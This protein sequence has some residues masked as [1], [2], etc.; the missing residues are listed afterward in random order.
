[1]SVKT[2][3]ILGSTGSI[4]TQ[5]VSLAERLGIKITSL[6]AHSNIGLL[7]VQARE[8]KVN[9]VCC[10]D[11]KAAEKLK[12]NLSDTS[13]RVYAG[14]GGLAQ[15]AA[16]DNAD[17]LLNAVVGI[18][19]LVPTLEAISSGKNIALANKET[20]VAGGKLVVEAAAKNGVQIIPVD[21]EHSAIFQC[22]R[23]YNAYKHLRSI[24]LTASGGA[25]FGKTRDELDRVARDDALTNP[26][27]K[28]GAKVTLDS[29]TLMN[30]GLEVIEA[31]WLFGV[32]AEQIEIVVHP[33]SA[34]H[35][36]VRFCDGAVV[37]Q[38]GVADM[39]LPIQYA[40]TFPDRQKSPVAD[41]DFIKSAPLTFF[42][43]DLETFNALAAAKKAAKLGGLAPTAL[44]A[45]N[46]AAV[47]LFMRG[48]ISF[49]DIG[50]I[51]CRTVDGFA[52][53]QVFCLKDILDTDAQVRETIY[54]DYS[55]EML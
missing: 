28:M 26:N 10:V 21:S 4:G 45:A 55:S 18:A 36:M 49:T 11:E 30:K 8:H 14:A 20:L 46:E 6:A 19:G 52:N 47:D 17:T 1:M 31:M 51:A 40:L 12:A 23:E 41:F 43:P 50:D 34:I 32:E 24:V 37:A 42:E 25:F 44:N 3:S 54:K 27:W 13:I 53:R 2:L 29:A 38:M 33:Q 16:E 9:S 15:L 5:T 35:S 7:E 39:R 48:R 22:L